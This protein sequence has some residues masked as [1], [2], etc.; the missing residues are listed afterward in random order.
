MVEEFFSASM[1]Y[2]RCAAVHGVSHYGRKIGFL[3]H[4]NDDIVASLGSVWPW[5]RGRGECDPNRQCLFVAFH[6]GR[7]YNLSRLLRINGC[8]A[9]FSH[10]HTHKEVSFWQCHR[11]C[12][13]RRPIRDDKIPFH[14]DFFFFIGFW[15]HLPLSLSFFRALPS[16]PLSLS[17]SFSLSLHNHIDCY[18]ESTVSVTHVFVK[19][20]RIETAGFDLY[21]YIF[22]LFRKFFFIATTDAR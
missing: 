22:S 9:Y 8:T 13:H 3:N 17:L 11:K 14:T 1:S 21:T 6:N 2:V 20:K 10:K 12:G 5:V 15:Q 18:N 19:V 4:T 16:L 7:S